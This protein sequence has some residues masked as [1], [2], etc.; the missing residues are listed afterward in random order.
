MVPSAWSPWPAGAS[1]WPTGPRLQDHDRGLRYGGRLGSVGGAL[2]D[3]GRRWALVADDGEA[4]VA[5]VDP[6]GTLPPTFPGSPA[7]LEAA[8][9]TAPDALFVSVPTADVAVVLRLLDQVCTL[10]ASASTPDE[11]R[12]LGVLAAS[13]ACGLGRG[14]LGSPSTHDSHLAT[15]PDVSRT[16]LHLARVPAPS[17]VGGG[18]VTPTSVVSREDLVGA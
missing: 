2:R 6:D 1:G 13:P 16:F 10:V 4:A 15:L 12:H 7:G 11:S 3:A 17:T 18:V 5:T 9:G 14:G 8:L